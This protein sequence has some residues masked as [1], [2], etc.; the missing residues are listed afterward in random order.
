MI[1]CF[2]ICT[3][4]LVRATIKALTDYCIAASAK[5]KESALLSCRMVVR[6][7]SLLHANVSVMKKGNIRNGE[8]VKHFKIV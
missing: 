6:S 8:N 5:H 2:V 1:I 3:L 4:C 7:A